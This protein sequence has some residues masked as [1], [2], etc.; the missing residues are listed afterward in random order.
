MTDSAPAV[1]VLMP[2][3]NGAAY[4]REAIDSILAQ[5][6]GDFELLILNDGS[7]DDS[8]AIARSYG[9]PRI[10]VHDNPRNLK[11]IATLN[12]GLALARGRYVARMDGDDIAHPERLARQVAFL[13]DHPEVG[14]VGC[15]LETFGDTHVQLRAPTA[16]NEIRVHL[17][18]GN[19]VPHP[20]VMF[21]R[22]LAEPPF[23]EAEFPHAE[24]YAAWQ[25]LSAHTKIA[26]LPEFLL[27]YRVSAQSVS[28]QNMAEQRA[29]VAK[30]AKRALAEIG[31]AAT[32]RDLALHLAVTYMEFERSF[33]FLRELEHWLGRVVAANATYGRYDQ[34]V[35]RRL[36]EERWSL[37][38]QVC[39]ELGPE[40]FRIG[41]R[42]QLTPKRAENL[43]QWA[44]LLAKCVLH[45]R[46]LTAKERREATA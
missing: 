44:R 15:W 13:D 29:S 3:Y 40:V 37:A 36:V 42:S 17:L 10:R 26:N 20:G 33:A 1:T 38:L 27:R 43:G 18:F 31:L 19:V 39:S 34:A 35:L 21:R 4:L 2:V 9:D 8:A 14:V 12:L 28:V 16:P 5:T 30:V 45:R 46:T 6:F 23:Y 7:T 24:D 32:P 22:A 25:R 41:M 11:L